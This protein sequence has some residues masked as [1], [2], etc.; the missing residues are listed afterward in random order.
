[1][2]ESF[3]D[4]P[5]ATYE[6]LLAID[7]D[8]SLEDTDRLVMRVAT[9]LGKTED[10]VNAMSATEFSLIVPRLAF[11]A[12]DIPE[13]KVVKSYK[14]GAF[15]LV[16]TKD[17][18]KMT[19]AQFLDFQT[20]SKMKDN[21]VAVLSVFLVPEGHKYSNGYETSE[22][23]DAIRHH[24]C[25]SDAVA[26]KAFF[27]SRLVASLRASLTYSVVLTRGKAQ[28]EQRKALR[29]AT[30]GLMRSLSGGVGWTAFVRP[31]RLLI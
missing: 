1:M 26:L 7:D 5:I 25:V 17:I 28:K 16:P 12:H 24:L 2:I 15:R 31:L 8:T 9:L 30:E 3:N 22:V 18:F 23:R 14:C 13:R 29:A 10:E 21:M 19:T 6:E 4:M 11:L 20:F 27:F